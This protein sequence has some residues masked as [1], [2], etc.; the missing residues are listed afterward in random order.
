[1]LTTYYYTVK[2]NTNQMAQLA[3]EHVNQMAA[4]HRAQILNQKIHKNTP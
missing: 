1:M 3:V 2:T 4:L